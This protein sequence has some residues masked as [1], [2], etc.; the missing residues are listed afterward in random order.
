MK[1]KNLP[2]KEW[3]AKYTTYIYEDCFGGFEIVVCD[4]ANKELLRGYGKNEKEAKQALE[5]A[6]RWQQQ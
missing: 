5:A 2:F 4:Y 1:T 3:L 6:W